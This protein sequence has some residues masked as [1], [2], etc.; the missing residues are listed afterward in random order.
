MRAPGSNE[1]ERLQ[2]DAL[3]MRTSS[4]EERR[5]FLRPQRTSPANARKAMMA[6]AVVYLVGAIIETVKAIL[7]GESAPLIAVLVAAIALAGAMFELGR[8][9]RTRIG[10][11]VFVVGLVGLSLVQTL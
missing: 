6:V 8:R 9:G 1:Y 7:G 3:R 10:F 5:A 11:T 2:Q 4:P